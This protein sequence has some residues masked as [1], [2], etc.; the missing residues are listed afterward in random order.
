MAD[1]VTLNNSAAPSP[2][3]TPTKSVLA[4]D[5]DAGE[6]IIEVRRGASDGVWKQL[7]EKGNVAAMTV[8]ARRRVIVDNIVGCDYRL[9]P[10]GGAAT[11][12]ISE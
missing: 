9:V 4:V 8:S 5:C 3:G 2:A 7:S 10:V 12:V 6:V 11:A 1:V